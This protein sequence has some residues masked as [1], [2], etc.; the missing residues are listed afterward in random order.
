[1]TPVAIYARFSTDRQDARS[2]EDQV[3]RCRDFAAARGFD[4]VAEFSD[5]A[6]SGATRQ[7]AGLK[8]LL[9]QVSDRRVGIK[10]VLVDDLS[11]LSRDLGDTWQI[12]FRD[13]ASAHVKV[14]DC[15]T[16]M[17]SDAAGARLTFGALALV[18][19]TFL[20]LVK[21]ETHRGLEGRAL[22]GFWT[23]GRVYGYSTVVEPNPP[24]PEHPRKVPIINEAEAA[25]V[26]RVFREYLDGKGLSA[27]AA[28]LN[29]DGIRAPYDR[30]T[31][32]KYSK[33]AGRGWGQTTVRAMLR[34]E[35]YIGRFV[36]NKRKFE[37]RENG[38]RLPSER[39]RSEWVTAVCPELAIIDEATFAAVQQRFKAVKHNHGGR[40]S[41]RKPSLFGGLL[42]C[43]VCGAGMSICS[44]RVKNGVRYVNYRCGAYHSKGASI[45]PNGAM[46]S[47]KK[48]RDAFLEAVRAV[49]SSPKVAEVFV[50]EFLKR[51][52]AEPVGEPT[53]LE[54]EIQE[55]ERH[56]ANLTD[57]LMRIGHSEAVA[58]KLAEEENRLR[59]LR[60]RLRAHQDV[61]GRAKAIPHPALV[62]EYLDG[63][64]QSLD[65]DAATL[66]RRHAG[67]ITLT[68]K[69]EGPERVFEASG[70]LRLFFPH[71]EGGV[72]ESNHC[73]GVITM[74]SR[75]ELPLRFRVVGGRAA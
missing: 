18:N 70:A 60:G 9:E 59:L 62:R 14:I 5:Q 47:E 73:G 32:L 34:N 48:V 54:K 1:V 41:P 63:V 65:A 51:V 15:T 22:K 11:R 6:V 33:R 19:D 50:E 44:A 37:R 7:R 71:P 45:C 13:L 30:G 46:I 3:R 52:G 53:E 23:G 74:L 10:A 58:S 31:G 16:G 4:V 20:Q 27:I 57:A 26:R 2:I 75:T 35:R 72:R 24:D 8:R 28:G 49:L 55:A 56:V 38:V 40:P 21:S 43:G 61:T 29:A 12:V 67:V 66:I 25:I 36:W 64:R 17:A 39:P 68:P 69:G 42:R